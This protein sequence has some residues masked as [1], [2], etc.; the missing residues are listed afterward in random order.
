MRKI[1]FCLF[2]ISGVTIASDF[3]IESFFEPEDQFRIDAQSIPMQIEELPLGFKIVVQD[4]SVSDEDFEEKKYDAREK[5]IRHFDHKNPSQKHEKRRLC[6]PPPPCRHLPKNTDCFS[7]KHDVLCDDFTFD[8]KRDIDKKPDFM[9]NPMKR[10]HHSEEVLGI[11][12]K[13]TR[14]LERIMI[15]LEKL[16]EKRKHHHEKYPEFPFMYD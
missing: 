6:P 16:L 2:L 7:L 4:N 13:Q 10:H 14:L 12:H 11:L 5:R 15:S 1:V 9:I 8:N 3:P